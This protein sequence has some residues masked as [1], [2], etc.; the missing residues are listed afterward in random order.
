[1]KK[2]IPIIALLVGGL[3]GFVSG[4]YLLNKGVTE[5]IKKV[6]KFKSYYSMLNEWMCLKNNGKRLDK[7]FINK[8]YNNIAIYGIGEMGKRLYEELHNTNVKIIY[9]IDKNA[10]DNPYPDLEILTLEDKLEKVDVIVVT[11]TFDYDKIETQLSEK[12]NCRIISLEDVL[13]DF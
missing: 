6:D 10:A 12:I 3:I 9:A 4:K 11:A 2:I 8:H 7:Y 1:M 13:Y 5:K